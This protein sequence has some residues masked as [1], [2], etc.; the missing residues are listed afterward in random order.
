MR[1]L[2][3]AATAVVRLVVGVALLAL[4]VVF[5]LRSITL[6]VPTPRGDAWIV[7]ARLKEIADPLLA[8][9]FSPMGVSWP[10]RRLWFLPLLPAL[11][12]WLIRGAIV[13]QLDQVVNKLRKRPDREARAPAERKPAPDIA[14][15]AVA[16]PAPA[17][18]VVAAAPAP[19]PAAPAAQPAATAP[20]SEARTL[21]AP[22]PIRPRQESTYVP[23]LEATE[24]Q[25]RPRRGTGDVFADATLEGSSRPGVATRKK[26]S[27]PSKIGRYEI[28]SELGRGAMG[29]VYKARDPQIGRPVAIK[30]I[31]S[32]NVSDESMGQF[33]RRFEVEARSAGKLTHSGIVAVH[34]IGED[35][36]GQ[37]S[38]IMEFVDGYTLEHLVTEGPHPGVDQIIELVAQVADAL[39]YAHTHGV[40]HRDIKPGN[41]LVTKEGVAKVAD[42][43]VAK[44]SGINLTSTGMVVGTPAFMSP[45]QFTGGAIDARSDIFSVGSVL[46]WA[47]TDQ[48]PFP[49]DT[50]TAIGY[51]V[52]YTE[53]IPTSELKPELPA[54]L[55]AIVDRCLRKS[56]AD[57]FGSAI[58]LAVELRGVRRRPGRGDV[59]ATRP[60]LVT[61]TTLVDGPEDGEKG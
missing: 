30:T 16:A 49:G 51:K 2:L 27:I 43:G 61:E 41:I 31:L 17:A 1:S 3:A 52:M 38:L 39:H 35:G 50:I 45:E 7:A 19:A 10:A 42:F 36:A 34:D 8:T 54:T 12:T 9:L 46:Y 58:Q 47:L 22:S 33:K 15:A 5:V 4:V 23:D 56:P 60:D 32:A 21:D 18:P 29:V 59:E 40:I 44:M 28:E 24:L 13:G 14:P 11:A 26:A 6:A 25:E 37:P 55:H 48:R 53:P 57:R 20:A